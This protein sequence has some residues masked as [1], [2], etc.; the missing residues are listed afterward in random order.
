MKIFYGDRPRGTPPLSG[1]NAKKVAKCSDFG[2]IECLSRK[3]CMIGGKFV[4]ITN[5]KSYVTFRLEPKWVILSDH[6]RRNGS[7]FALF[8]QIR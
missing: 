1:L 8:Y 6:E 3:R 2:P 4:L 7:Y 5:K